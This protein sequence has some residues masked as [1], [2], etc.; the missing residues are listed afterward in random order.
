MIAF[1][2]GEKKHIYVDIFS[3]KNETFE[4][5]KAEYE[6]IKNTGRVIEDSGECVLTW[7]TLDMLISPQTMGGYVLRVIYYIADEVLVEN[8]PIQVSRYGKG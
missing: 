6:L 1:E 3:K 7:H 5:A 4:I 2:L 8:I